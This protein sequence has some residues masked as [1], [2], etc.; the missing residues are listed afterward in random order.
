MTCSPAAVSE[1]I[2]QIKQA[3]KRSLGFGTLTFSA[4]ANDPTNTPFGAVR[5]SYI[6]KSG[7]LSSTSLNEELF[8]LFDLLFVCL[9]F[10]VGVHD[11][12]HERQALCVLRESIVILVFVGWIK[13]LLL[14]GLGRLLL[15]ICAVQLQAGP[16]KVNEAIWRADAQAK[17]GVRP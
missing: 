4:A 1:L 6:L 14:K 16:L 9:A 10:L 8:D 13:R 15:A 12:E 5:P 17:D 2:C 7:V 3:A 11:E